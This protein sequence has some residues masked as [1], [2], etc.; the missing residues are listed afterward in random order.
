MEH[1]SQA[2]GYGYANLDLFTGNKNLMLVRTSALKRYRD[3][4]GRFQ[5]Q[6]C[7]AVD[8]ALADQK[9]LLAHRC[10]MAMLSLLYNFHFGNWSTKL[11]ELFP[12]LLFMLGVSNMLLAVFPV[13][14]IAC[15]DYLNTT[16][17]K[18]EI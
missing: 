4:P 14:V 13:I 2:Y 6:V 9:Q 8:P 7:Q 18:I 17:V 1:C 5:K 15:E 10:K 12:S 3:L 16:F 11:S